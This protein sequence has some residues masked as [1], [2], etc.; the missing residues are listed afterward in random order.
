MI[1]SD[2]SVKRPVLASVMSILLI[3]FG[4][5]NFIK[6]PLR[7]FPDVDPP[8]VSVRTTYPGA[9]AS[10]VE[11]RITKIIE[12]R[13]A[14]IEAI[15]SI[16]SS[17]ADGLSNI[18]IEFST[19]RDIDAAANDVRD[20]VSA[21][22]GDLPDESDP[23]E[24]QKVSADDDAIAW[25]G[26][27]STKMTTLELTDY[28]D[29]YLVD[30][31]SALDGVARVR[32]GGDMSY[33]M[34]IWLDRE[35][36][37][38]RELTVTDIEE[39]LRAENVELPA[40]NIESLNMQYTVRVKRNFVRPGDFEKLVI[41]RTEDYL[42]RLG[43]VA[44]VVQEA[45]EERTFY[46]GNQTPRVGIGII[47]QSVANTIDV[48]KNAK[49]EAAAIQKELPSGT[50]I[51]INYDTS[52]FI[53]RSIAEVYS[54]LF[55]SII[56]VAFVIY[57]FLGSIRAMI[58]PVVTVPVSIIATNLVLGT[59]G[60]SINLL[61]LLGFVL[62]IGLVVDDAIVVLE[63]I[64]RIMKEEKKSALQAAYEGSRQVGFAVIATT[65]VLL[66]VFIPLGMLEGDLGKLFS[67]FSATISGAV[68]FSSF[69]ALSL[70]PMIASLILKSNEKPSKINLWTEK[71]VRKLQ[72]MYLSSLKFFVRKPIFLILFIFLSTAL[73]GILYTS[74]PSEYTPKE[75]RGIM[76][77][78]IDGPEGASYSYMTDYM[79]KVEDRLSSFVKSGEAQM[80]VT[81]S[82][83]GWDGNSFN[84]GV[85]LL[86]LSDWG[87]RRSIFEIQKEVRQKLSDLP[88]VRIFSILP[89]GLGGF[90]KP[91]QFVIGGSTYQELR[92]VRDK[93]FERINKDN[94][95]FVGLD[96]DYK[97][98]KPQIEIEVDYSRA[99]E[100][101]ISIQNIGHTLETM[102][103]SRRV[104]TYIDR[105]EEYD[106]ILEGERNS[107]RSVG[108]LKNIYVRSQK[109]N[110]LVP[111]SNL[112]KVNSF[113]DANTLNR[114]NRLRALTLSSNLEDD[115]PLGDALK[116]LEDITREINPN[117]VVDY[118]GS[119]RDF[120]ES[121]NSM[122][123]IFLLGVV[124]TFLVLAG[125][126][127]SYL[128]PFVIMIAVPTVVMGGLIG[129]FLLGGS[130]NIYTQIG[131]I[132]LVGLSAKN[133]ILI[134]EFANQ[135]RDEG[136]SFYSAIFRSSFVR[137]RPIIM[138]SLTTAIGALPLVIT[139]GAGAETRMAIG[140][141]MLFGMI[142]ATL[143]TVYVVP[144]MYSLICK[145]TKS[146]DH[147]AQQLD[148]LASQDL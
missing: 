116:Y 139:F 22:T 21:V 5:I 41:K 33:A 95:G 130:I 128:H 52:T 115:F 110:D 106:V 61:T 145:N 105:G 76:F 26:L 47:K 80:M 147:I 124:V 121:G 38:A 20:R 4:I 78:M 39:A 68:V 118:K 53:E 102:L 15:E 67:E 34:R 101:G 40:G 18:S 98:T 91:L 45:E 142:A 137:L 10:V 119:S 49:K 46:R 126:F 13:I 48:V 144:V 24:I 54:T 133:G 70:C 113:A 69:L 132:I 109:S 141:V 14:G 11:T 62:A 103:G 94:P 23:P 65:L 32:I 9:S 8:I 87:E 55:I 92:E 107:Q 83:R 99:A 125:Q 85:A 82:P 136:H 127:E 72:W 77:N 140:T 96:H 90:S 27:T 93:I 135:L 148:A 74:L 129:V 88:G 122:I 60:Y 63:N 6:L 28:A 7:E 117:L 51:A 19:D 12:D 29:R 84:S 86:S 58:V 75:D 81:R 138:T 120:K 108:S 146:P 73:T 3:I 64:V 50:E 104:T 35:A 57:I 25:F 71:I 56:L 143:F 59:L 131:L 43:D 30:R 100:M 89:Q 1:L 114:F 79:L 123:F 37:A 17:S 97:E 134:V 16:T 111:L 2:I 66:A 42:V 36:L 44:R 31:F 112:V